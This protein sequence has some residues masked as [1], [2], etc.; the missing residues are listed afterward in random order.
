MRDLEIRGAG[1]L[2]G[3]EQHGHLDSVGYDLYVR[4]LNEAVLEEK[5]QTVE[6]KPETKINLSC[7]AYLPKNYVPSSAQRM[8]MYKK[9]AHIE[10]EADYNDIVTEL[11]DRFGKLPQSA[12]NLLNASIVKAYASIADIKKVDQL[13]SE[14]RLYPNIINK[15]AL[16]K[17]SMYDR[18]GVKICGGSG[19]VPYICVKIEAGSDF[20]LPTVKVLKKYKQILDEERG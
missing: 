12:K 17:L 13:K 15:M 9:I 10:N 11:I 14:V 8:E 7:D 3:A 2:L 16:A 18:T 20:S 4:L 1:N 5:G 6:A 19:T